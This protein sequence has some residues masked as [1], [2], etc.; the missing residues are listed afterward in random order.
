MRGA[1][2]RVSDRAAIVC[3]FALLGWIDRRAMNEML[4]GPSESRKGYSGGYANVNV[5]VTTAGLALLG[6][7]AAASVCPDQSICVAHGAVAQRRVVSGCH[8]AG[9]GVSLRPRP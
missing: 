3:P 2:L 4:V 7:G 5:P 8:R 9:G 1:R 6:D